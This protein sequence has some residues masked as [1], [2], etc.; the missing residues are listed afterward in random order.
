MTMVQKK[1]NTDGAA[2]AWTGRVFLALG[3]IAMLAPFF[4]MFVFALSLI[5]I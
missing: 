2:L 4:F 5:H 1:I 3:G